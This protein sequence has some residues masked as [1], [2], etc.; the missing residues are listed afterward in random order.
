MSD[1]RLIFGRIVEIAG[2]LAAV[3]AEITTGRKVHA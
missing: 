2:S 3:I 1:R